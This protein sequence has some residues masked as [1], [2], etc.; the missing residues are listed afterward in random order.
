MISAFLLQVSE[1]PLCLCSYFSHSCLPSPVLFTPLPPPTS[2]LL[3]ARGRPLLMLP[4][5]TLKYQTIPIQF[6]LSSLFSLLFLIHLPTHR[7]EPPNT[8]IFPIPHLHHPPRSHVQGYTPDR[9]V[10][11]QA[12]LPYIPSVPMNL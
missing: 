2:A 1:S 9:P 3:S 6:M 7:I 10:G 5:K 12:P 8:I 4:A 11:Y